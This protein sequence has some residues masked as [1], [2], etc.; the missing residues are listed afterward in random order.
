MRSIR[1]YVLTGSAASSAPAPGPC[2]LLV[3]RCCAREARTRPEEPAAGALGLLPPPRAEGRGRPAAEGP[4]PPVR[5]RLGRRLPRATGALALHGPWA[6]A[7]RPRA[8]PP[9]GRAQLVLAS[10]LAPPRPSA[11][12][13]AGRRGVRPLQK[14]DACAALEHPARAPIRALDPVIRYSA[15]E[16][17]RRALIPRTSNQAACLKPVL[18]KSLRKG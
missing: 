14:R 11:V 6:P 12:A 5:G 1:P 2:L 3:Q 9:L 16:C 8:G 17:P 18:D 15:Q 13:A 4:L 10:P 7:A